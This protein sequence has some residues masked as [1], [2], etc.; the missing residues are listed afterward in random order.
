MRSKHAITEVLKLC[1]ALAIICAQAFASD[2]IQPLNQM[3]HSYWS[4]KDGLTG[5]VLALAQTSDGF[6]WIGTTDGLFRFDGIEFERY[7]PQIGSFVASSVSVLKAVPDRGLW[8]GYLRGGAAFLKDGKVINYSEQDGFPLA[9]VRGFARDWDGTIWAAAVGGFVR[10]EGQRWQKVRM[11]WNYPDRAPTALFV[12]SRGVLWVA[13]TDVIM[14]L[15]KGERRFHNTGIKVDFRA[16]SFAQLADGTICFFDATHESVRSF[17]HPS[18]GASLEAPRQER[19]SDSLIVD[20]DHSLWIVD[21]AAGLRRMQVLP[22]AAPIS[23]AIAHADTETFTEKEGLTGRCFT[24]LEDREGSIWVG[25]EG[26]LERFRH[27]NLTWRPLPADKH[28]F[29]LV[30]SDGNDVWAGTRNGGVLRVQDGKQITSGP[31]DT[32]VAYRDRNGTAWFGARNALWKLEK[33]RFLKVELPEQVRKAVGFPMNKDPIL[34][35][36]IAGDGSDGIWVS[37]AGFGEFYLKGGVWKFETILKEYPDW[38]ARAAYIDGR[39]QLWLTFGE[40]VVKFE[41]GRARTYSVKKNAGIGSPNIVGGRD[42]EVY[43]GGEMGIAALQDDHFW[44]IRGSDGNDFGLITGIVATH[45][46]GL[47]LAASAGI[48]HIPESEIESFYKHPDLKVAYELFDAVSDMPDPIQ[49]G[50]GDEYSPNSVQSSDGALWFATRRGAARIDPARIVRNPLPPPVSIRSMTA[51]GKLL[52][53]STNSS[54]SPFT[55]MVE[56]GYTA[57]SLAVPERVR[58]R[59]KLDGGSDTW[60]DVG[61]RRQVLYRDLRPGQY[62]FHVIAC[63][64]DGVWNKSGAALTFTVLPAWYQTSVFRLLAILFI[65]ASCY[66]AYLIEK[67]RYAAKLRVRFSERLEERTQLARELH[68]TLLQTIQGSKLVADSAKEHLADSVRTR[69]SL[70][71]ISEWLGTAV[72]DVRTALA[73]LRASFPEGGDLI[74]SLNGLIN[75][76]QADCDLRISLKV[77]GKT[78]GLHPVACMEIRSIAEEALRN[79]CLHSHGS[80]VEVELLFKPGMLVLRVQDNG[81]GIPDETLLKGKPGHFGLAGMRE[82]ASGL[83]GHITISNSAKGTT[84]VLTSRAGSIFKSVRT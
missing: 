75:R 37:I 38:A 39:D 68:D 3:Y 59:C 45:G 66:L 28:V 17:P 22:R 54:L 18:E 78:K 65:A 16:V 74:A 25:T 51:D 49:S 83:G 71:Y 64:N 20:H 63:N 55:K 35:T 1:V 4:A 52:S 62:T 72:H 29:S 57:L 50:E 6:L 60:E 46:G 10:L 58:F 84:V 53:I 15:P 43:V 14:Y 34:I 8:I 21:G 33:G 26:G 9:L 42:D 82:R 24:V 76:Y 79:A 69:Q 30:A 80:L 23:L 48:V 5:S 13:D 67:R 27:R 77:T 81:D 12:D 36:S 19:E 41:N 2:P 56:I 61:A 47:W 7:L 73:S 32:W 40:I 31:Q 44:P 70:D 11:N